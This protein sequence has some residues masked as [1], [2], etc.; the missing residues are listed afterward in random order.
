[1]GERIALEVDDVEQEVGEL[2][3]V[4]AGERVL[5]GL[6]AGG[7]ARKHDGDLAVEQ[8]RPH[9]E[10]FDGRGHG[11]ELRRPVLAVAAPEAGPAVLERARIR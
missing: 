7:P 3:L 9:R 2:T 8:R 11:G 1:V 6:E 5:E 10:P 4:L